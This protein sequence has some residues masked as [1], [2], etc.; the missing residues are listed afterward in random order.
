MVKLVIIATK[1]SHPVKSG[2]YKASKAPPNI[3]TAA[4]ADE[5]PS[6]PATIA[7]PVLTAPSAGAG[8]SVAG[9]STEGASVGAAA[10]VSW[11]PVGQVQSE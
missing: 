3:Y 6:A 7:R 10:G 1:R 5:I 2:F 11:L 4:I 8:A 9:A